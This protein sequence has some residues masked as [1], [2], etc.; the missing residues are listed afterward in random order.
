MPKRPRP[1]ILEEESRNFFRDIIPQEWLFR[2]EAPDYGIDGSVEIFGDNNESIALRFFVQLKAT[3]STNIKTQKTVR[4]RSSTCAYW[5]KQ[6][7]P[8]LLVQYCSVARKAYWG[9][10]FDRRISAKG[11]TASLKFEESDQWSLDSPE[12]I[13]SQLVAITTFK[14]QPTNFPIPVCFLPTKHE[15]EIQIDEILRDEFANLTGLVAYGDLR[16]TASPI[17]LSC[18]DDVLCID[19]AGITSF[20]IPAKDIPPQQ[21]AADV[22]VAIALGFSNLR[23]CHLVGRIL[24]H[25]YS[26]STLVANPFFSVWIAQ[27]LAHEKDFPLLRTIASHLT[28]KSASY[29][30]VSSYAFMPT[31]YPNLIPDDE[32][33]KQMDFLIDHVEKVKNKF[34]KSHGLAAYNTAEFLLVNQKL[35]LAFNTSELQ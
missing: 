2:D 24:K 13:Q 4:F 16:P 3:D 34:P 20:T 9:W 35:R 27:D 30:G 5:H 26:Q 28:F 29:S 22:L 11:E 8:T 7:Q 6:N 25:A 23:K 21:L 12:K 31:M 18:R 33:I 1:H 32:K 19:F 14:D 15:D 10:H 17:I